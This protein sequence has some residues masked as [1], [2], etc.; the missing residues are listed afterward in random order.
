MMQPGMMPDAQVGVMEEFDEDAFRRELKQEHHINNLKREK[1]SKARAAQIEKEREIA[2]P[3]SCITWLLAMSFMFSIML[4]IP[5]NGQ[6]WGYRTFTGLGVKAMHFKTS[7]WMMEVEIKCG[8]NWVEDLL[9]KAAVKANGRHTLHQAV[10]IMCAISDTACDEMNKIYIASFVL[11]LGIT[12]AIVMLITGSVLMYYYWNYEPWPTYRSTG[13]AM[14]YISP[15]VGVASLAFWSMIH[16]DLA[17]FPDAFNR[18]TSLLSGS[19]L[20]GIKSMDMLPYGWCFYMTCFNLVL[21]MLFISMVPCM[22]RHHPDEHAYG[23]W[24]REHQEDLQE[25]LA[26]AREGQFQT[27]PAHSQY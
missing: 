27:L 20:F 25:A 4:M 8:K 3:G 26:E 6:S 2:Q 21:L 9:C 14:I 24:N 18:A 12:S 1:G 19:S 17:V 7:L 15:L 16:P 13:L 5:L 10:G 22:I 23:K 11:L